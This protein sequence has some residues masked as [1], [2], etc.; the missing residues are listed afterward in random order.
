[1]KTSREALKYGFQVCSHA[2]GDR[3]NREVLDQ[4]ET[5][6]SEQPEKSHNRRFRIEHAQHL[7]PD[8]IPRFAKLGVIPAMQ[9]IHMS[10]DRPWAIKRLGQQRI[11]QGAYMWQTLLQSGA[12]IVNGTDVPVEPINPIPSF[13][14]SVTRKTLQGE[15]DGGYE[16]EQKM[17]RDQALRSYTLDAAHGA[18]EE[19]IKGSIELGK[20]ADFT[21]FTKDIMAVPES[22]ILQTEVAMTVVGGKVVYEKH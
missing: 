18:F 8:D 14:A 16:P 17:T 20:L 15:P 9:A 5:A 21:I 3:A 22:E 6:F 11:K 19:S 7:H 10:S 1:L 4:Y 2:I 13:Y 12:K